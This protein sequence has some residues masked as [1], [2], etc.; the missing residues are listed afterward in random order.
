MRIEQIW[1]GRTVLARVGQVLLFPLHLVYWTG[2]KI[3]LLIYRLGLKKAVKPHTPIICV[4]NFATG[5]NG[6]TPVTVWIARQLLSRG[7]EVVIG[8]SGYG[9]PRAEAATVAPVGA[10]DPLEWGDEPAEFRSLLPDVPLIIGRRRVLAAELCASHF[11]SAVL[12][13]DDGL[14]H[15]PLGKDIVIALDRPDSSN[16]LCFPAGPYREPRSSKRADLILPSSEFKLCYSQSRF[17]STLDGSEVPVSRAN[18]LTAIGRPDLLIESLNSSVE[19]GEIVIKPDHDP[20]TL[21]PIP[22]TNYPWLVTRKD[23]VKLQS[24]PLVSKYDFVLID[25]SAS[26][27][28]ADLF[29]DWLVSKIRELGSSGSRKSQE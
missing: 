26:I 5:G 21:L 9:S 8:C 10:L 19:W 12:L 3:Y 25:R 23:W 28:P 4:G 14:Q 20:L 22:S 17:T 29:T 1:Y 27:E 11:P 18:L 13:M 2:W 7:F 16:R 24:N 6:K 15:M